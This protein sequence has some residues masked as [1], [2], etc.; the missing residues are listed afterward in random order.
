MKGENISEDPVDI[1]FNKSNFLPVFR[2]DVLN[3]KKEWV[4]V[5]PFVSLYRV[6][7]MLRLIEEAIGKNVKVKIVTRPASDYRKENKNAV[8]RAFKLMAQKDIVIQYQPKIHQ[9]FAI[10]DQRTVWYGSINLL[11]Y[12]RSEESI[13]RIESGHIAG[14]LMKSM[15]SD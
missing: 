6:K 12:G 13:M 8:N 14:V 11:S 15:S 1:I 7:Q 5:S 10:I 2:N 4:V 9:K 3:A